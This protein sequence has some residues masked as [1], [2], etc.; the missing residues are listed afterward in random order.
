MVE[1]KQLSNFD[2]RNPDDCQEYTADEFESCV[3][4]KLQEVWKPVL[5]CNPP[6]VSPQEQCN[7][8]INTT[9][10][11]VTKLREKAENI[12]DSIIEMKS[13]PAR[14]K[15]KRHCTVFRS[16]FFSSRKGEL[17]FSG[18]SVIKFKFDT[19]IQIIT[20]MKFYS[21]KKSFM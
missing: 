20:L 5:G 3:D 19:E 17:K 6:W 14:E 18:Y 9:D 11:I 12:V 8:M 21:L 16:W 2:P 10:D 4:E 1:V 7:S 15:C 13:Y